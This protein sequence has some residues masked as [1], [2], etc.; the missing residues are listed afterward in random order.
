MHQCKRCK[1]YRLSPAECRCIKFVVTE[2]ADGEDHEI[3]ATDEESAVEAVCRYLNEN[4]D[5]YMM[6]DSYAF[7]CNGKHFAVG[8]EPDV[9]YSVRERDT[10]KDAD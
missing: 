4:N 3:W 8:V 9:Y 6:N 7:E 10:T 5:Y 2:I 1:D